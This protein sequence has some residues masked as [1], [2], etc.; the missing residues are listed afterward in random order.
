MKD[1]ASDN[2]FIKA[3]LG[4]SFKPSSFVSTLIIRPEKM[5]V[6]P[7]FT[8][9]ISKGPRKRKCGFSGYLQ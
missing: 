7:I 2:L 9:Y 3:A 1:F 4:L 5:V 6:L 8:T